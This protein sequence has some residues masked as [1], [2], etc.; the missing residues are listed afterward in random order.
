MYG[1]V[2]LTS[3]NVD[4]PGE[5]EENNTSATATPIAIAPRQRM[6]KRRK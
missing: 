3:L 4:L 2:L 6:A 5:E 1:S